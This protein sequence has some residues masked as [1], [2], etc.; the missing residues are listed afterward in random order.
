[1]FDVKKDINFDRSEKLLYN[2]WK[3][4]EKLNKSKIENKEVEVKIELPK[5]IQTKSNKKK[6]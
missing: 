5:K 1:M 6:G 4:L 2:I 3:E